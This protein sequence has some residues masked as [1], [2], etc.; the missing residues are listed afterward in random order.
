ML[1][2]KLSAY[3]N[4]KIITAISM[5]VRLVGAKQFFV[6]PATTLPVLTFDKFL[7]LVLHIICAEIRVLVDDYK[8][9]SVSS[10][11]EVIEDDAHILPLSLETLDYALL[12]ISSDLLDDDSEFDCEIM[13]SIRGTLTEAFLSI[14][15]FLDEV[16]VF[17]S[18]FF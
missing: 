6:V 10:I 16:Y 12:F 17:K 9:P 15:A 7:A 4:N 5:L 18:I 14:A 1:Q 2:N 13:L 11:Q 3:Q 8:I